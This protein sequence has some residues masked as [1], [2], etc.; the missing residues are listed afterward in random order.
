M[1]PLVA[2]RRRRW[3]VAVALAALATLLL[4]ACTVTGLVG[5]QTTLTNA[6]YTGVHV[7]PRND[8]HN[9]VVVVTVHTTGAPHDSDVTEVA[10]VVWSHLQNRFDSLDITVEG[11]GP[12][13]HGNISFAELQSRFGPR[14]PAWN[15]TSLMSGVKGFG[16]SIIVGLLVLALIVT[17]I[18]V[19]VHQVRRRRRPPPV[20]PQPGW[21]AP[22]A[23]WGG[24]PPGPGSGWQQY[25]PP[26]DRR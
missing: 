24:P 11:A 5:I 14:N 12:T 9:G 16:L 19:L 7:A 4:S 26:A 13:V 2:S 10:R 22:A 1:T 20:G 25:E 17:G 8:G 21:G 6:G 3:A 15:R 23:P 18:V